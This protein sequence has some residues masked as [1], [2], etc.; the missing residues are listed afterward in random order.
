MAFA[1]EEGVSA[2]LDRYQYDRGKVFRDRGNGYHQNCDL[3]V[4][5]ARWR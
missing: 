2:F 1:L 5:L 3:T 4:G